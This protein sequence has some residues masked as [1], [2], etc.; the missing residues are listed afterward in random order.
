MSKEGG[1]SSGSRRTTI[2]VYQKQK[3]KGEKQGRK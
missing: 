1:E 3:W 2:K